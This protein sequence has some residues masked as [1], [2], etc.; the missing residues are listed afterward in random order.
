MLGGRTS[1]VWGTFYKINIWRYDTH[2]YH[3]LCKYNNLQISTPTLN[4]SF[5]PTKRKRR[6]TLLYIMRNPARES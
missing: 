5:P 6:Q 2:I 1:Q 3:A 4:G